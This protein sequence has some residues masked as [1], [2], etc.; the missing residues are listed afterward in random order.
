MWS[1]FTP[2]EIE[3]LLLSLQVAVAAVAWALPPAVAVAFLLARITRRSAG[4]LGLGP[5]RAVIAV[6]KAVSVNRQAGAATTFTP[7]VG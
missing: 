5:G 2:V 4:R 7:P 6:I 1:A 3:A